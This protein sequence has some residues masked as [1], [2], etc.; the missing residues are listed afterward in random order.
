MKIL[1]IGGTGFIG[2]Q[3]VRQLTD[4]GYS[5]TL[6]NSGQSKQNPEKSSL[7]IG[8]R[9]ELLSFRPEFEQVEPDVVLDMIPM[10]EG[11]A[12]ALIS[13]FKGIAGRVVA[14]SSSDVYRN[15]DLARGIAIGEAD[16]IPLTEESPLRENLFPYRARAANTEDSLY[17]YEKILVEQTVMNVPELPAT[18]LRLPAVYGSGDPQHRLFAYL[19]RMLDKRPVILLEEGQAEWRWTRGYVENVA[20]A[21]CLAV[22]DK[23]AVG[24]IYNVGEVAGREERDWIQSIA[25]EIGWKGE[26]ISVS[27]SLLPEHMRG[28]INW[29]HHLATDTSRIRTDLGFSDP[30]SFHE[31]LVRTIAWERANPAEIR[32]DA[33]DYEAEDKIVFSLG[34]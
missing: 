9:K 5:V 3:V 12:A 7:I 15:Y 25:S 6:F 13:T 1:I 33:F 22:G 16:S 11:D 23:R 34:K 2:S 17:H 24:R 8:D 20:A 10:T 30:V 32:P 27:R 21:I 31:S 19:K 29:Q 14:I 18:V 4:H 28:G 26:V